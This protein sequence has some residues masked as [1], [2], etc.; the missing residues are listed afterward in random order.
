M[1]TADA[2]RQAERT[3]L[4]HWRT[5]L[6]TVAVA[7]LIVRQASPG[8]ERGLAVGAV[9]VLVGATAAVGVHRQRRLVAGA[10]AAAPR[11]A[12]AI[13]FLVVALQV[14]ALALVL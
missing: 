6:A 2:G 7:L 5:Q 10:T 8:L 11:T 12:A 4:A 9:V 13:L 3:I 1:N 14:V